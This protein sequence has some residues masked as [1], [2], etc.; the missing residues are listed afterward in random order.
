[1]AL[2]GTLTI[3]FSG[4]G[5]LLALV[6]L[7]VY[8]KSYRKVRARFTLTLMFVAFFFLAQ[9]SLM[10]YALLTMMAEF[11]ALVINIL[12]IVT[13]F[14]DMALGLLLYNSAK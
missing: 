6:L 1:M 7:L 12:M 14:G 4:L 11:T 8:L 5:A 13:A 9:N 10:F 2:A 3:V